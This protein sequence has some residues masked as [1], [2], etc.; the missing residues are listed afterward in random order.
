[1]A[2]A[3]YRVLEKSFINNAI[4]EEGAIVD[5]DFPKGTKHGPNL[6]PVDEKAA[7]AEPK[8]EPQA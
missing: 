1:M 2:L 3:K 7:P 5:L 6:E 8:Q 4:V